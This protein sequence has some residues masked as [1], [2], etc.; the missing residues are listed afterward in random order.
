MFALIQ[1]TQSE[2]EKAIKEMC[3]KKDTGDDVPRDMLK[4]L[5]EGC[6]KIMKELIAWS[7]LIIFN[8][9]PPTLKAGMEYYFALSSFGSDDCRN[10]RMKYTTEC[11]DLSN[12]FITQ[13]CV[14]HS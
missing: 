2:V 7:D 4:L 9:T 14:S 1:I 8:I 13:C 12:K 6:S 10:Q 11:C 5:G 3:N